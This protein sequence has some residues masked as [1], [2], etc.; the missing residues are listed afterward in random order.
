M[1]YVEALLSRSHSLSK[2]SKAYS[3]DFFPSRSAS[4]YFVGLK[5][6]HFWR[7]LNIYCPSEVFYFWKSYRRKNYFGGSSH[8]IQLYKDRKL[9]ETT[10]YNIF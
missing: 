10:I 1:F 7:L 2:K 6:S 5:K 3:I 9:G 4:S 8:Y